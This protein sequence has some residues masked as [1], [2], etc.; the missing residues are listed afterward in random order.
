LSYLQSIVNDSQSSRWQSVKTALKLTLGRSK[1]EGFTKRLDILRQE[2]SFH[3]V[4]SL[5]KANEEQHNKTGR[6]IEILDADIRTLIRLFQ[7]DN[8][9]MDLLVKEHNETLQKFISTLPPIYS[10]KRLAGDNS[11]SDPVSTTS[12]AQGKCSWEQDILNKDRNFGDPDTSSKASL[13]N[14]HNSRT[15]CRN[16]LVKTLDDLESSKRDKVLHSLCHQHMLDRHYEIEKAYAET[17]KWILEAGGRN[18][19]WN[20]YIA[21]L[22]N[23]STG[24]PY[25]VNGKAGSGKSTL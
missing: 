22:E 17:F 3:L 16:V 21:F 9:T 25:W 18:R 13:R 10:A 4:V 20:D 24:R 19:R 5:K 23:K 8:S 7:S 2:M 11:G 14:D 6:K 12:E 15:K 1:L